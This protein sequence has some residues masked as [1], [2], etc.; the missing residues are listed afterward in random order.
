MNHHG[1][2]RRLELGEIALTVLD[3]LPAPDESVVFTGWVSNKAELDANSYPYFVPQYLYNLLYRLERRG[4]VEVDRT[5][6][7][8]A[9]RKTQAGARFEGNAA[10]LARPIRAG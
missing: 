3:V 5:L 2:A 7:Y 8:P 1:R 10:D 4:L 9:W 6:G